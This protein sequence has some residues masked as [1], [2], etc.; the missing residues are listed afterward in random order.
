MVY[1]VR[2]WIETAKTLSRGDKDDFR[3]IYPDTEEYENYD[4][5]LN[6]ENY[7]N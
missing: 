5:Y 4:I 7:K 2:R 6:K 1:H 3:Q